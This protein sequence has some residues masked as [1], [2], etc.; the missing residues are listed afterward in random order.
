[1]ILHAH[2]DVYVLCVCK[3]NQ[4]HCYCVTIQHLN[5]SESLKKKTNPKELEIRERT[6]TIQITASLRSVR[7]LGRF[8]EKLRRVSVTLTWVKDNQLTLM[9]KAS[10]KWNNNNNN[11][12]L[13]AQ[14]YMISIIPNQCKQFVL[15]YVVSVI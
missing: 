15:S 14:S 6:E 8:L 10:K 7:I 4:G 2:V 13:L 1:M 5:I 12:N 3:V 11:S 9:W